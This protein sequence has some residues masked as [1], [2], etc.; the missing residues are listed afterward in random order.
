WTPFLIAIGAIDILLLA[1]TLSLG[2]V[3]RSIA[4]LAYMLDYAIN[5]EDSV[6]LKR[7]ALEFTDI[8]DSTAP[9]TTTEDIENHNQYSSDMMGID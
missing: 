7:A 8:I 6:N 5:S 2:L 9:I 3:T 1:T 4:T